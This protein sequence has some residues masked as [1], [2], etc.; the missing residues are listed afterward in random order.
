MRFLGMDISKDKLREVL[1]Q[2]GL[3]E[4]VRGEAVTLEDFIKIASLV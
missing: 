4:R 1:N 2:I 3:D